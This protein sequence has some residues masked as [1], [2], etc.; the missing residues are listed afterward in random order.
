MSKSSAK[1]LEFQHA[2]HRIDRRY[3]IADNKEAMV[4]EAVLAAYIDAKFFFYVLI[5]LFGFS[6]NL[7]AQSLKGNAVACYEEVIKEPAI[8]YGNPGETF[9]LYDGTRWRVLQGGSYE[10]VP[11]RYKD[12]TICPAMEKLINGNRVIKVT[13]LYN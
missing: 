1:F 3:R 10:Y 7:Y 2:C 9:T 13:K 6:G 5:I 12:I 4:L 8:F 11:M